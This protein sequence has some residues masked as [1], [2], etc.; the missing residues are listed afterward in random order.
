M[1]CPF[2]C[3]SEQLLCN[4]DCIPDRPVDVQLQEYC[5]SRDHE[6]CPLFINNYRYL[7]RVF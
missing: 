3:M 2:L 7:Y 5:N 6:K 4:A 1:R